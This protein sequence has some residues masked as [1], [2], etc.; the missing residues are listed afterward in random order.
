MIFSR[1]GITEKL[2]GNFPLVDL[3]ANPSEMISDIIEHYRKK[4][5]VEIRETKYEFQKG[6]NRLLVIKR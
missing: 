1:T 6:A 2:I 5:E 3:D 4:Y